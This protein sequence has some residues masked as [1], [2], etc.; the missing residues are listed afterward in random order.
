M[1][2]I[3]FFL[4]LVL[5]MGA[6]GA[7]NINFSDEVILSKLEDLDAEEGDEADFF[8]LPRWGADRG[9]KILVN[10]DSFGAVGDGSS[11]DTKVIRLKTGIF[12]RL[13]V[14]RLLH[15][16]SLKSINGLE[17]C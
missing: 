15:V 7:G 8:D 2:K 17:K 1:A 4:F 13:Y 10:V 11:D 6:L 14:D 9:N 5:L 16:F 3:L 12:L